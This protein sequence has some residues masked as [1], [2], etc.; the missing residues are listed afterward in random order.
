MPVLPLLAISYSQKPVYATTD[1]VRCNAKG[2]VTCEVRRTL[3]P[4]TPVNRARC[5]SREVT[6]ARLQVPEAR[7][8][9]DGANPQGSLVSRLPDRSLG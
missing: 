2:Y 5:A 6:S 4:R 9:L 3:L 7:G 8:A 1:A